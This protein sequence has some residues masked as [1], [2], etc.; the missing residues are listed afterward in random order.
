MRARLV[1]L[2]GMALLVSGCA[3]YERGRFAA[4]STAALDLP[5]QVVQRDAEGRSC[6]AIVASRYELAVRDA[7][8]KAGD[9]NALVDATYTFERLCVV[10]RGTAVRLGGAPAGSAR[11]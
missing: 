1:V 9:A 2:L 10:V 4:V 3:T 6:S 7:R 8:E 11:D 5:M